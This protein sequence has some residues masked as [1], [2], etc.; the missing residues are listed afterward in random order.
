VAEARPRTLVI[1]VGHRD[2]GDDAV[3]RIV[4]DRLRHHGPAGVAIVD[5][6]GEAGRLLDLFEGADRVVII[7]AARSGAAPGTIQ[8][9][10]AVG[11]ALPPDFAVST[12]AMGLAESIEL[13]RTL[14]RLPPRCIVYAIEAASF[15][16][17]APLSPSVAAV[18]DK[19]VELAVSELAAEV[20]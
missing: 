2:R 5:T 14:G 6:D 3:G 19:V 7:D 20:A 10:D 8:R 15:A 16:L 17:G 18:V 4:A 13:A 9:L 11:R 12:H 1:G